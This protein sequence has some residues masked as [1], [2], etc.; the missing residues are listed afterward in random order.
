MSTDDGT[1]L[2]RYARLADTTANVPTPIVKGNYIFCSAGFDK[3]GALLEL[4]PSSDGIEVKEL[5]YNPELKNR[6]GGIVLVDDYLYG[7]RDQSGFP[8]C[9][10]FKTGRVA[11]GWSKR[12]AGEGSGSAAVTYADGHLY[13]RYQNGIVALVEASLE[14][15]QEKGT[16]RIPDDGKPSWSH[17]VVAGGRVYLRQGD[18]LLCYDVKQPAVP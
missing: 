6:H 8:F 5:Y 11:R 18:T 12:V 3:G 14:G 4:A 2:W 9:A 1:F 13:F 17:P 15:Y 10:E 7:D 16:L